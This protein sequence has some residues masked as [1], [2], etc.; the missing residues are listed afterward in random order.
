MGDS[1]SLITGPENNSQER[2]GLT[3]QTTMER[4]AS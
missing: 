3:L 4:D 2:E 1:C